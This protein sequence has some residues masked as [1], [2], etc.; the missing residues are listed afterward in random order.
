LLLQTDPFGEPT[1]GNLHVIDRVGKG[2]IATRLGVNRMDDVLDMPFEAL[3]VA[4]QVKLCRLTCGKES[5]RAI[6][7]E[8]T[9]GL[10]L[11]LLLH[12]D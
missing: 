1:A 6:V 11:S 9:D 2:T 8:F 4:Q 7:S 5:F 10:L 3:K 12:W